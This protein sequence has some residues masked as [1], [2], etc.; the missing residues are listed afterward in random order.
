MQIRFLGFFLAG[1]NNW[2]EGE[3]TVG[4]GSHP[5][6]GPGACA[7]PAMPSWVR[8]DGESKPSWRRR[9]DLG[10]QGGFLTPVSQ[11]CASAAELGCFSPD[12]PKFPRIKRKK[13]H[14]H[15]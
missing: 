3:S 2:E 13:S 15:P 9:T 6:P 1:K 10:F 5:L 7:G 12:A 4:R 8:E 14:P 11:R